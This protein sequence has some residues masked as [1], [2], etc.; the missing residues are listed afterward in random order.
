VVESRVMFDVVEFDYGEFE[1]II[2]EAKE[3]EGG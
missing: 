1:D 3:E 2:E